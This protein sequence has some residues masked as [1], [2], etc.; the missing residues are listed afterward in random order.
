MANYV[1]ATAN[2]VTYTA[3]GKRVRLASGDVWDATD[4]FVKA[5]PDLFADEPPVVHSTEP[6]VERATA[7][8]GE[9]RH[10][11]W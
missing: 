11:D 5:R 8:P 3:G 10:R 4:P 6:Q 7:A 9:K 2:T 1:Y